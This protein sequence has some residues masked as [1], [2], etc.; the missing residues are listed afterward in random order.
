MEGREEGSLRLLS[1]SR[2][3]SRSLSLSSARFYSCRRC[4]AARSSCTRPTATKWIFPRRVPALPAH[5]HVADELTK[6]VVPRLLYLQTTIRGTARASRATRWCR[7]RHVG[8][9][10]RYFGPGVGPPVNYFAPRQ[11]QTRRWRI[12][13]RPVARAPWVAIRASLSS[14]VPIVE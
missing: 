8:A 7:L 4:E 10:P 13:T 12:V 5:P 1:V 3:S 2:V 11:S 6:G 9:D 14:H